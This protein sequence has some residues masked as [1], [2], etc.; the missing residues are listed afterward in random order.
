MLYTR[1]TPKR[2]V[3]RR[4]I[5]F[6]HNVKKIIFAFLYNTIV[7]TI[8][9]QCSLEKKD[10]QK[11]FGAKTKSS[12][13]TRNAAAHM[14]T[15]SAPKPRVLASQLGSYLNHNVCFVGM[16]KNVEK[17]NLQLTPD[18]SDENAPTINVPNYFE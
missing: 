16:V 14:S 17:Q 12:T 10:K 9:F 13:N 2:R 7:A 3:A 8:A 11:K 18:P 15:A 5:V 6:C 1:P 4:R